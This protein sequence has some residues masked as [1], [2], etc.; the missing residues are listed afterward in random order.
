MNFWHL[1][2]YWVP[3]N[4]IK[5]I[6]QQGILHNFLNLRSFWGLGQLSHFFLIFL[7]II[8]VKYIKKCNKGLSNIFVRIFSQGL[9]YIGDQW[10]TP[11][12]SSAPAA[13]WAW[14][15]GASWCSSWCRQWPVYSTPS[16][17]APGP[18]PWC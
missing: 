8:T 15:W 12:W 1:L 3:F 17:E 11:S 14:E 13:P 10:L 18:G 4:E 6:F 16:W 7:G 2:P 9:G 5:L